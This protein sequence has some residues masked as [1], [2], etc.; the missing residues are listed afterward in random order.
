MTKVIRSLMMVL[1]LGLA[2]SV[3][4]AEGSWKD[5]A[6][7]VW[8][9][10]KAKGILLLNSNLKSS[11]ISTEVKDGKVT[12]SGSVE[13]KVEKALAEE[14]VE[15]LDGVKSVD[16][17]LT[18][19]SGDD[20]DSGSWTASVKDTKV[21][22]VIKTRFLF[23]ADISSSDINVDVKDGVVTLSG[24]VDNGA[25]KDLVVNIAKNANDVSRVVDTNLKVKK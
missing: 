9:D 4:M 21:A 23:E 25:Q 13:S 5:G 19:K 1:T 11:D 10:G 7:D 12:L 14:L 3:V 22:A 2:S 8:I 24:H 18:V 16:N 20:D 6:T 15:G 17:R